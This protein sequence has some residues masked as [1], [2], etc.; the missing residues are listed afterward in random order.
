LPYVHGFSVLLQE[1]QRYAS[2]A[3]AVVLCLSI[4]HKPILYDHG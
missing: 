1:P 4:S 2:M 3:F